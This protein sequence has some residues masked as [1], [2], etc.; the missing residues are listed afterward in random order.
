[1]IKLPLPTEFEEQCL[2]V[3]Y[4]ELKGLL[5]SKAAQETFT[6]SWNQKR[7]NKLSGLRK[8]LPDMFVLIPVEKSLT[9]TSVLLAIEMKR[10]KGGVV[11]PEQQEWQ[12]SLNQVQGVVAIVARGFDEAKRGVDIWLK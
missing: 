9:G 10:Q 6:R 5:F 1:M 3:E 8:G 12:K 11:S 7:K 2:L 4:L